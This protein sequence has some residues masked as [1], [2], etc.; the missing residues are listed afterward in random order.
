MHKG[1]TWAVVGF[2]AVVVIASTLDAVGFR[3]HAPASNRGTISEA[4]D[5]TATF[6]PLVDVVTPCARDQL[7]LRIEQRTRPDDGPLVGTYG[8]ELHFVKGNACSFSLRDVSVQ[9]STP[10][11]VGQGILQVFRAYRNPSVALGPASVGAV[12]HWWFFPF[13]YS[14]KCGEHA[15]FLALAKAGPY[16]ASREVPVLPCGISPPPFR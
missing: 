14:P 5:V 7:E 16:V 3:G 2:V 12:P 6:I 1:A 4:G 8:A 9:I 15:P 10:A 11:G 13:R